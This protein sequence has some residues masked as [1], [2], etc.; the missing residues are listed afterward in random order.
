MGTIRP[1]VTLLGKSGAAAALLLLL[2]AS[3][4]GSPAFV[5]VVSL[6]TRTSTT[7]ASITANVPSSGLAAGNSLVLTLQ[8]GDLAGGISCSDPINGAYGVDVV[9]PAGAPGVAIV[10]K[11]NL[12]ATGFGAVITC[13]YPQFNGA[14]SLGIYEFSGLEPTSTLDKTSAGEGSD[15]GT[16]SSGLTAAV[17]Q[18]NELV[19]GFL[20]LSAGQTLALATSGGNTLEDPYAPPYTSLAVASTQRPVYR[21]VN[22]IRQFEA[23]GTITGAGAWKALV[24]TYRLAPDPCYGVVCSDGNDC[25][26]DSCDAATGACGHTPEAVGIRCGN[27][28]SGICDSADRCDGAGV[29]LSNNV[30]NGTVCG[31]PDG[32]C[33]IADS[34]QQG[35]CEPGGVLPAG[36]SCGDT[37]A[38]A[39]DAADSCDAFGL[40]LPNLAA[41]GAS[42]GDPGSQCTNADSCLSGVCHDNGYAPPG[43]AC[44]DGS[45]GACD[46]ADS[47]DGAGVCLDNLAAAGSACNDGEECTI[48][49][50]CNASGE[51]VGAE[52]PAC[53]VCNENV[54]PVI[55]AVLADPVGAQSLENGSATLTVSFEDELTQ[56]HSC[57]IDWGDGSLPDHF[58]AT[59]PTSTSPGSCNGSHLYTAVGVFEVT[60]TVA[61]QCGEGV[62]TTHRYFVFYDPTA[63]FVTGGG[64][65]HSP[66]GA[67]APNPE[68]SGRADFGFV[69][70]Y[71]R[72]AV[73]SGEMEFHLAVANFRFDSTSYDW[74]V[75]S[76]PKA[77][78][79]GVGRVNEVPGYG[80]EVTAW[81]GHSPGG[82]DGDRFR[83]KIWQGNPANIVY[84]NLLG[85]ADAADPTPLGGGNIV[86]HK[87]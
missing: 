62:G 25:T 67:Y 75:L 43:S 57:I 69:A 66:E 19:V 27:P 35:I 3:A 24:A 45:S 52:N 20:W 86:I 38:S 14:S 83:I 87:K 29:C 13:N 17:S 74:L 40:C 18:P 31:Q 6:R 42:C 1:A 54:A 39:C 23:N 11:H 73:A 50:A 76:G 36:S 16:A 77:R 34:C 5:K 4:H 63:G 2:S 58:A 41:D 48:E 78:F 71:D 33:E 60:V 64:W 28:T 65:I 22:S 68:L 46:A 81:D 59:E 44:G 49:D 70:R 10:S 32:D 12:L 26:V 9:S 21:F 37:T 56:T 15:A 79:R 84:D 55:G 80:F 51:C 85:Q 82:G 8:A 47:C 7:N 30:P 61:D 53:Q 72:N